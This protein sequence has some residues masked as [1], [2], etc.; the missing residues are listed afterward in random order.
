MSYRMFLDD[1][2]MPAEKDMDMIIVR[3]FD[4]AVAYIKRHGC[5]IFISFDHDLCFEHYG[6]M[7]TN[8]KT[9]YDLAKWLVLQDVYSEGFIPEGFGFQV[10]SQNPVGAKNIQAYLSRYLE[11]RKTEH[12]RTQ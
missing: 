1:E 2:R 5:P 9:G 12:K 10:H 11:L 8:E 7:P 6:N 4:E 3:S